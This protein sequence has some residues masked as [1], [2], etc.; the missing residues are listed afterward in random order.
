MTSSAGTEQHH[1]VGTCDVFCCLLEV[2]SSGVDTRKI[3]ESIWLNDVNISSDMP[4]KREKEQCQSYGGNTKTSKQLY[5]TSNEKVDKAVDKVYG[6]EC[7]LSHVKLGTMLVSVSLMIPGRPEGFYRHPSPQVLLVRIIKILLST[8]IS[9]CDSAW[10]WLFTGLS[11]L[12]SVL[13]GVP[14]SPLSFQ[15]P[16]PT[17][18]YL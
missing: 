1:V 17:L 9:Q 16:S 10:C 8:E 4:Y 3:L 5:Y 6:A 14:P 11:W 12:P 18:I 13:D 7:N 15:G 2:R